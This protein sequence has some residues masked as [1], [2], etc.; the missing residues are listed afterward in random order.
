MHDIDA[1]GGGK[2]TFLAHT[3]SAAACRTPEGVWRRLPHPVGG[4]G[5]PWQPQGPPAQLRWAAAATTRA[6]GTATVVA[7][8]AA[9]LQGL[10]ET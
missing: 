6:E 10:R 5:P 8:S 4:G 1:E 7:R 2:V 9:D 3:G